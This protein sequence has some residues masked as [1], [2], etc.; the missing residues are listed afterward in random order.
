[1]SAKPRFAIIGAG[2][3]GLALAAFLSRKGAKVRVYEQAKQFRRIGAG[4]QMSPN[5]MHVLR[6]RRHQC[7]QLLRN[8]NF[9]TF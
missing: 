8:E 7:C 2:I 6:D 9:G 1:M 3:G 4:I 5:A